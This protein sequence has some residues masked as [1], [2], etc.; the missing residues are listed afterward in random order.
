MESAEK[1]ITDLL[2]EA[3]I[4]VNGNK[5]Y[6][7]QVHNPNF[8]KRVLS[9]A[10]LGL[11]ESYVEGWWDCKALDKF[12]DKVFR[13]RLELR[14]KSD[15]R[16]LLK[17]IAA[18]VVNLQNPM[19]AFQIAKHYNTGN[20]LYEKML[21]KS[22]AYSCAY[23]KKA[24]NLDQAQEDKY[25]LLCRK[26]HLK[27]GMT[28]LDIGCGWGGL[29]RHA[30]KKYKAKVTGVTVSEEQAKLAR[31]LC[32]G[33]P[34]EIKVQDYRDIKGQYDRVVSVGMAEHVGPKNM[35]TYMKKIASL[36][37]DDGIF[38]YHSFVCREPVPIS[39]PWYNKYIF[40]NGHLS[41]MGQLLTATDGI[42]RSED[43]HNLGDDYDKTVMAWHKNFIKHW[44]EIKKSGDYDERFFR[45]WEYYLLSAAA[46]F[47][48]RQNHQLM[49]GVLT[50]Y[51]FPGE[52]ETAR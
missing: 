44:P 23:W 47:R 52:Y 51:G 35:R 9:G 2:A 48:C 1:L 18:K 29:A 17:L 36:L 20:F 5:P 40:P 31:E 4:T 11:G 34:V 26:L 22:M 42:L 37:K 24:K 38:A 45:M 12:F 7:I 50:K 14:V 43:W 19:R 13:A 27:P 8:F 49:Q 6:D 33:L 39:D 21:G 10:S 16:L 15:K 25:D 32:K 30:A 46:I 41:S 3:G 28:L